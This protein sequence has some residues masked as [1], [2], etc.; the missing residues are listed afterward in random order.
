MR[1]ILFALL[2]GVLLALGWPTFGFPFIL[3][4]AFVPLLLAEYKIR[5]HA[6]SFNRTLAFLASF[7]TF[8]IWNFLT[9][10]WIMYADI[11]G[12]IVAILANT[13]FMTIVMGFYYYVANRTS[14]LYGALFFVAIWIS[15]EK[16]HLSWQISWPW[17]T[18]GNAFSQY[19]ECVQWYEF[20]GV[21]GGSLW[22]LVTNVII[23]YTI[24][25]YKEGSLKNIYP[26][27]L[28]RVL[29]LIIIPTLISL[30]LY[31]TY[32]ESNETINATV[33]QP[34]IDPYTTKFS[35]KNE[36][37]IQLL[38]DL[39]KNSVNDSTA[40]LVAPE[41]VLTDKE[42]INIDTFVFS[43]E[44]F[45]TMLFLNKHPKLNYLFGAEL[46]RMHQNKKNTTST[47]NEIEDNLWVDSFNSAILMGAETSPQM[48]HKS[49]FVPG[50]ESFPYKSI[51]NPFLGNIMINMGG[52]IRMKTPQEEHS[53]FQLSNSKYKVAPVI[54]YESIY[55][56]YV[57]EFTQK[58]ANFIAIMTNDGWWKDTQGHK[59]HFSYAKLRAIENRKSI[60]RSANTG[61]SGFINEKGDVTSFIPYGK[62]DTLSSKITVNKKITIYAYLGDYI[63]Y[64]FI[65]MTLV[66]YIKSLY[67]NRK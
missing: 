35:T 38:S 66:M 57:K 42:G 22:I 46:Y 40:I 53:V 54:C 13:V 55:G 64:G 7:V 20:T 50:I 16:L 58:G 65:F 3:F 34:N 28:A 2:S 18:L 56:T 63:S 30:V 8:L 37:V 11:G 51:F 45:Q 6:R 43:P 12:G 60:V 27:L 14:L 44:Q 59:Q 25:K 36:K 49:K 10:Y 32:T 52:N 47:S 21:F 61:I 31:Y 33:L 19:H 23:F 62:K 29:P 24:V 39:A 15:F 5:K 26:A 1:N 48:Y 41:T 9:S 67:T 17:L 4:F